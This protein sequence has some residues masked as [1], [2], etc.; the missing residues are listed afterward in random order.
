M[1]RLKNLL[2]SLFIAL[3]V[4]VGDQLS[5]AWVQQTIP[6]YQSYAPVPALAEIARFTHTINSGAAF[7]MFQNG[8]LVF[9]IIA[10]GVIGFLVYYSLKLPEPQAWLLVC[11]GLQL[12]GAT[13]NLID[14]LRQG[15]VTDFVHVLNFPIFN[16]ADAAIS[17]G[18][19]ML[20]L[21][22]LHAEIF[23]P[24]ITPSQP[25]DAPTPPPSVLESA[26][27]SPNTAELPQTE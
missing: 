11:I 10:F 22:A 16:V 24:S 17:I 12:G 6:L 5:K 21:Q 26:L 4:I 20:L 19:G 25:N 8:S 18:V 15:A 7:G 27:A 2:I 3:L 13:G 23:K 1:N 14:R 9:T